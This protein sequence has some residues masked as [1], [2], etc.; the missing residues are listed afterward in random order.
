MTGAM[1]ASELTPT[2]SFEETLEAYADFAW[3]RM[4]EA[5]EDVRRLF[6]EYRHMTARFPSKKPKRLPNSPFV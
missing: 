2:E 5:S 3:H 1:C 4:Q 6:E